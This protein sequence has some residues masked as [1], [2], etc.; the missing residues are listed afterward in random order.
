[1][2]L[3]NHGINLNDVIREIQQGKFNHLKKVPG[4][5]ETSSEGEDEGQ[6]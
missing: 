2:V 6:I 4:A 3:S 5:G 1:M